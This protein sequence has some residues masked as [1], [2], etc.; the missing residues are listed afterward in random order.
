[1]IDWGY[2]EYN[3]KYLTLGDHVLGYIDTV[4]DV[5]RTRC[6]VRRLNLMGVCMGGT[7]AVIYA[8]L[9]PEKVKNLVSTV[10]PL[11]F[12]TQKGLLNQWLQGLDVDKLVDTFG[13]I[14]G[15]LLN[16]IFLLLNPVR[17]LV[18]KYVTFLERSNETAYVENFVRMEKWIF[19]SPDV[20][21][22]TFRQFVK[23]CY[24]R[25]LLI[26]NQMEIDGHLIDL[27]KISMPVLN[28]YARH[29]H[30]VPWETCH[31]PSEK[32]ASNDVENICLETGHIG[33]Y[34]SRKSQ[35]QFA[36]KIAD[37]LRHRE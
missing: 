3:D 22:E 36:P 24:Q 16:L 33:I 15:A 26:E 12:R 10:T 8:A 37:W 9:F 35:R 21:G 5:I 13:N 17:L 7:L 14:P 34:V 29:D 18:D 11:N 19:D 23:D 6:K 31:L 2:P 28:I 1:M 25:N 32:V 30:L 27:G 20:P 4:V